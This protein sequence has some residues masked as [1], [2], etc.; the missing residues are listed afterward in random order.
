MESLTLRAARL[1]LNPMSRE[2]LY[3]A[4]L[5]EKDPHYIYTEPHGRLAEAHL[6][7][8]GETPFAVISELWMGQDAMIK[9]GAV[10]KTKAYLNKLDKYLNAVPWDE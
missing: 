7:R 8:F 1:F 10:W 3:P 2:E 5:L 9:H 6:Q 4:F